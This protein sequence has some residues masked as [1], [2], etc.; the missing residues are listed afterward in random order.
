MSKTNCPETLAK[1]T[2]DQKA[3]LANLAESFVAMMN[4]P[5]LAPN[6]IE[7]TMVG[8]D[9]LPACFIELR[10]PEAMRVIDK[11]AKAEA[12]VER[13]RGVLASVGKLADQRWGAR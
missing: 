12:E 5:P 11:L 1:T 2:D 6:Y 13:L 8:A 7:F 9:G 4:T 10:R 3:F